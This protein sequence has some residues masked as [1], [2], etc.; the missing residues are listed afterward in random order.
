[1]IAFGKS[2]NIFSLCFDVTA[3]YCKRLIKK[4]FLQE[5]MKKM[6]SKIKISAYKYI[7]DKQV[8]GGTRQ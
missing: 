8:E 4:R 6:I 1:M 2:I 3:K 5:I 7:L